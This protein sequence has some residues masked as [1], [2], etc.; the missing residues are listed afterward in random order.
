MK[1]AILAALL[2]TLPTQAL[3]ASCKISQSIYRDSAGKGFELMFGTAIPGKGG[4]YATATINHPKQNQIYNFSV[5]QSNGYGSI[6]FVSIIPTSKGIEDGDGFRINFFDQNLGSA[7][8]GVIGREVEAPK[9]VFISDLGGHDYYKRRSA[10]SEDTP[11]F[12]GDVM[13]IY[14][15]C[16]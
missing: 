1:I 14:E 13:W 3:A 2:L 11:P 12:L 6:S 7:N 4:S 9:Y 8:P 10:V 5:T 16:R 15:R